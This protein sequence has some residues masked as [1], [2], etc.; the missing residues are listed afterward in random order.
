MRTLALPPAA[1]LRGGPERE[2]AQ[3]VA[4]T[5]GLDLA[6]RAGALVVLLGGRSTCPVPPLS[7]T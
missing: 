5:A 6:G 1:L 4:Q 7:A 2:P 3:A